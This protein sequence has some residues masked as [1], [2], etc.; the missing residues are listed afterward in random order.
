M[1]YFFYSRIDLE[2]TYR[3]ALQNCKSQMPSL[4]LNVEFFSWAFMRHHL[5]P[6]WDR[7]HQIFLQ[8][9]CAQAKFWNG[10]SLY[11][12][13]LP[14][15]NIVLA[16]CKHFAAG[17]SEQWERERERKK[18]LMW[19]NSRWA[20]GGGS[21]SLGAAKSEGGYGEILSHPLARELA[22]DKLT[23]QTI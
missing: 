4:G 13:H 7:I 11:T 12:G 17:P 20:G 18:W 15:C 19:W 8:S 3:A 22:E 1:G 2:V 16:V 21:T 6:R 5:I 10:F 9:N 23:I 14:N